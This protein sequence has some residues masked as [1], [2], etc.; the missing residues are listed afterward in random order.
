M[1]VDVSEIKT[2][3][4]CKRQ[5]KLSSRNAF[6]LVPK[7]T[8]PQFA[9]GTLFH[10][11]LHSLYLGTP[12]ER[13][14][15]GVRREMNTDTDLALISMINGYAENVLEADLDTYMVLDIEHRFEFPPMTSDG[16]IIDDD[17][18]ICGSIDMIVLNRE[19]NV[20]DGFEHK[21]TKN[22]RNECYNWMDEQPR[23]YTRALELY[24]ERYNAIGE[25]RY[26]LGELDSFEPA[27]VGHIY[28]N[29]VRKLIRGFDYKRTKCEYPEGDLDNFMLAFFGAASACKHSAENGDVAPPQPGWLT[30]SMCSFSTICETYMYAPLN[31]T[32]LLEEFQD[33]FAVREEDHLDEKSERTIGN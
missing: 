8:P 15:E 3:H 11:A 30:C 32:E 23:V 22:F 21:S 9:F 31:L 19:T 7:V 5:W 25:Q 16:E 20:I 10:E 26:Q 17:L 4:T 18:T 28:V 1:R 14:V 6:H 2:Y 13:V 27:T 12:V 24:V 29:E 33:E